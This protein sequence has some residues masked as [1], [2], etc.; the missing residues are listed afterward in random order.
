M[1]SI[2]DTPLFSPSPKSGGSP[3]FKTGVTAV[4]I[5][6]IRDARPAWS[7][8]A[9]EEI[10]QT[11]LIKAFFDSDS[12]FLVNSPSLELTKERGVGL[13]DSMKFAL[14]SEREIEQIVRGSHAKS[15][16]MA[17]SLDDL[18]K[19]FSIMTSRKHGVEDKI[20]EVAAR[21]C[22]VTEDRWLGW[23]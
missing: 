1:R 5:D 20:R 3:D 11:E 4:L 8:N 22:V 13:Q 15:S 23:K 18:I 19:K 12:Q 9:L 10:S 17:Y 2:I 16:S 6:K 21:R 14:P 7:P